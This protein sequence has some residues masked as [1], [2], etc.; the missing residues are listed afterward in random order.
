MLDNCS[1][2]LISGWFIAIWIF[3]N[4]YTPYF[5][6]G[7]L[8]GCI[9]WLDCPK[10]WKASEKLLVIPA[11]FILGTGNHPPHTSE[12]SFTILKHRWL[13]LIYVYPP[14]LSCTF[15][16]FLTHFFAVKNMVTVLRHTFALQF[17]INTNR[18]LYTSQWWL[19]IHSAWSQNRSKISFMAL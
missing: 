10:R 13:L 7:T 8:G 6:L 4:Y 19:H 1:I 12:H 17:C 9:G 14:S 18:W 3:I 16:P 5:T 15:H 2:A 11:L